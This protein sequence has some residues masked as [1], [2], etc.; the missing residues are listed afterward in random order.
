M[1]PIKKIHTII[2]SI[3]L[4]M[5]MAISILEITIA[6]M[7]ITIASMTKMDEV[8]NI[9]M[10]DKFRYKTVMQKRVF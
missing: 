3:N 6:S 8:D 9:E 2:S 4:R 7:K 1:N 5:K 10:A